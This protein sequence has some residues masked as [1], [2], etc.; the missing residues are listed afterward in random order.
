MGSLRKKTA[1][2]P[3]PANAEL[4][5][6]KGVRFARWMDRTGKK[7]SAKLTTGKDGS[8][9][10]VVESGK[11]LAKYRDG[12]GAIREV[13]TGCKDRGA[14][15]TM[16]TALERR[17]EL[18]RSGVLM[19]DEDAVAGH[20]ATT[21]TEH[22]SAYH[23]YRV[24]QELNA[25]RIKNTDSR[26]ER[27]SVECGFRRLSDLSGEALT[28]WLGIQLDLGMGAGTRNEYLK[29][30]VG[31]ANWCVRTGRLTSNP[32]SNIP[33]ANV[34][35]DC[36]RQRRALAEHELEKLLHVTR[37]RPLAEYGRK[38]VPVAPSDTQKRSTWT[39]AP[40][41][42]DTLDA[43]VT[44]ARQRLADNP[45]FAA[46]LDRRGRERSL[47]YKTMILT[48]LRRG[49][50]A[51]LTI[52]SLVLDGPSPYASLAAADEK[53]GQ[54]SLIALRTDLVSDLRHWVSECKAAYDGRPEEFGTQPLFAVPASLLR[55]LNCDLRAAGI[56]KVDER[57]RTVDL[58]A[59]R[60]TFATMLSK[61]GVAPRTAQE[62]MRHSDIRLTMQT[63]T[64]TKLFDVAGALD[65]LP[66]LSTTETLPDRLLATCT[67]PTC[68]PLFP[69]G[70]VQTGQSES[71]TV[72]SAGECRV[73]AIGSTGSENG[74]IPTKKALS[75]VNSDNRDDRI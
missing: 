70:T 13:S 61:G 38:V 39:K 56:P 6:K 59:M 52:G 11:W 54:G 29:E 72:T 9:R 50:L 51:S 15:Q 7:K 63:Y 8:D 55:A 5:M 33:R 36:R 75:E 68:P 66:E 49:E 40:I 23:S 57:G 26:L 24:T 19:A 28:R 16:L 67:N 41:T 34:K 37:W 12:S 14:A 60:M 2:K 65:V 4:Y 21:I 17:A 47:V 45:E 32:F 44:H 1:T 69:P 25:T 10:I 20:S 73:P 71:S 35:A 74:Q 3:M 42:L 48:G 22:I 46:K 64:D 43:A 27:L 53:N 58:H 62:L 18:V 31:F 30:L